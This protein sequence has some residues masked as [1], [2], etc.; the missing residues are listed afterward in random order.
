MADPHRLQIE[1]QFTDAALTLLMDEY[2]ESEGARLWDAYEASSVQM[3][4]ALDQ[5]CQ[6]EADRIFSNAHKSTLMSRTAKRAARAAACF[7]LTCSLLSNIVMSVEA[8]RVPLLNFF[9]TRQG[10]RSSTL[11][12]LS[13]PAERSR[14]DNSVSRM[15]SS[16]MPK[17]F[18]LIA[19]SFDTTNFKKQ[20]SFSTAL[21]LFENQAG[22]QFQIQ[23]SP[24]EG[25]YSIDTEDAE[26]IQTQINGYDA[27]Y[28]RKDYYRVI[29]LNEA[30]SLYFSITGYDIDE[31]TFEHCVWA[32]ASLDFESLPE[33]SPE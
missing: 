22:Q 24:A 30:L 23:I 11:T 1:T 15:V 4:E 19:E 9:L 6:T 2:A 10:G 18:S 5:I 27:V 13:E 26:I 25:T 16:C 20:E 14:D 33:L 3:P 12:F 7:I 32:M 28:I 21:Y 17:G 29:W 31:K 8:F